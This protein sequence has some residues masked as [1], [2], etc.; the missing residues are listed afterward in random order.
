MLGHLSHAQSN[1]HTQ[2]NT[3]FCIAGPCVRILCQ[4]PNYFLHNYFYCN[5]QFNYVSKS[6]QFG[7]FAKFSHI[8]V[9]K[10]SG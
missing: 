3:H 8:F 5:F 2:D 7:D 4:I 1:T 6:V 9:F 10:T